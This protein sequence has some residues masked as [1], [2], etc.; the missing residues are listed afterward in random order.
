MV[1]VQIIASLAEAISLGAIIPF[2]TALSSPEILS[3]NRFSA[4]IISHFRIASSE[5]MIIV[6]SIVFAIAVVFSSSARLFALRIQ[7]R[8]TAHASSDLVEIAY[9]NVMRQ[10][11]LYHLR[12]SASQISSTILY[13]FN[14]ASSIFQQFFFISAHLVLITVIL[15]SLLLIEPIIV[16][17]VSAIVIL[18][19]LTVAS[20]TREFLRRQFI[21]ISDKNRNFM[22]KL[23][24][25]FNAAREIILANQQ[26][27]FID[28]L[29]KIDRP[30]RLSQAN[31][32]FVQAIPRFTLEI[33]GIITFILV[34]TF[35]ALNY[36]TFIEAVPVIGAT[37]YATNRLAPA[38]HGLY[39][40]ASAMRAAYVSL[41]RTIDLMTRPP[42]YLPSSNP[43]QMIEI[44]NEIYLNGLSFSYEEEHA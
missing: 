7:T 25:G 5:D 22:E 26:Q 2:L 31:I 10:G 37:A 4:A 24:T 23:H 27:K 28:E 15:V 18:N 29:T 14:V 30:M 34:L 3:E 11:Y 17:G 43:S 16:V 40:A 42:E 12:N 13:D 39:T 20:K 41:N 33:V 36:G 1:L 19:Y 9:G 44:K 32:P 35:L 21:E 6:F 38:A 8:I